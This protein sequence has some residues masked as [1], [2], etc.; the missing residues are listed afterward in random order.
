M[1]PGSRKHTVKYRMIE[2]DQKRLGI[3]QSLE[4]GN[5]AWEVEN[6]QSKLG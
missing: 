1:W 3:I 4:M 5:V 2:I 6:T